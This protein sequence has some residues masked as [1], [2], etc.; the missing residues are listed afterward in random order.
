M[1]FPRLPIMQVAVAR[2][3]VARAGRAGKS[4]GMNKKKQLQ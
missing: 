1:V 4:L 2:V 3:P